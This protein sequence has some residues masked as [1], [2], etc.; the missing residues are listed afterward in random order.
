MSEAADVG[1]AARMLRGFPACAGFCALVGVELP[2]VQ[3][4]I[5]VSPA[6]TAAVAEAG[7]LGVVPG[8]WLAVDELR[9]V[10]REMRAATDR[11]FALNL[12]LEW[13]QYERLAVVLEEGVPVISLFW[14]DPAPYLALIADAD[15]VSLVTVGSAQEAR[16]AVAAG[17][18]AVVAQGWEA[19]GHVWGGVAGLPLIP[20][21]ADAVAPVPVGAAGGVADG[22]GL[23]A[24]LCLG[25]GAVWMGTRFVATREAPMHEIYKQRVVSSA[26][27][28][29]VH[30]R[31]FDGGWPDAPHRVLVNETV[32]QWMA[33][34]RPKPGSR[35]GEGDVVAT[36]HGEPLV[37]YSDSPPTPDTEGRPELLALY[38]GQSS[39]LVRSVEGA[40]DVVQATV[41]DAAALLG[42]G[43]A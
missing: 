42:G 39:G 10:I 12:V 35:P 41:R 22:R 21:V 6:L 4:P 15:A 3:A 40:R 37:R 19:G 34:G 17:A 33:A 1:A 26:E 7:G 36:E 43:A 18:R 8:S 27:T 31:L 11:P 38:A 24:A 25:A 9:A 5:A 30:T 2:V 29:T 28:G 20:A 32:E 23:A 16:G 14:G 13:D